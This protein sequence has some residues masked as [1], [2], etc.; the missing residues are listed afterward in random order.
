LGLIGAEVGTYR[1][2]VGGE[3]VE[4]AISEADRRKIGRT[5][6]EKLLGL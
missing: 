2:Y 6:A 4:L 1:N 3:W 5:N